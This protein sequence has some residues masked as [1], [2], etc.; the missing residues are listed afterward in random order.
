[1]KWDSVGCY[2]FLYLLHPSNADSV[3]KLLIQAHEEVL[4]SFFFFFVGWGVPFLLFLFSLFL[5]FVVV[6]LF[7]SSFSCCSFLLLLS[8][9]IDF[10]LIRSFISLFLPPHL[11]FNFIFYIFRFLSPYLLHFY[12]HEALFI[13]RY[14]GHLCYC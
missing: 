5:L 7:L 3:K 13:F 4:N 12:Y 6:L 2:P 8:D 1:M 14:L 10:L 9:H 11:S